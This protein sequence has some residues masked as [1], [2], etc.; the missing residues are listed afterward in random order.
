M[1]WLK[2]HVL[3]WCCQAALWWDPWLSAVLGP[4]PHQVIPQSST[5][6][7]AFA[8]L[9]LEGNSRTLNSL[10]IRNFPLF[11]KYMR[12]KGLLG[13]LGWGFRGRAGKRRGPSVLIASFLIMSISET[14][15]FQFSVWSHFLKKQPRSQEDYRPS[16]PALA[17]IIV[18]PQGK[19][20]LFWA[21]THPIV[22][23]IQSLFLH[24]LHYPF[25]ISLTNHHP[26]PISLA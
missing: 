12:R 10:C 9:F 26:P 15:P 19:A 3:Y 25:C 13:K 16:L 23:L 21:G 22:Q 18:A 20:E 7:S 17:S 11:Q 1:T 6:K 5:S 14:S 2:V 4:I 24:Y 8:F